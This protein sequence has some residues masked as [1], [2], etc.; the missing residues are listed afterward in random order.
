METH[1]V[2]NVEKVEK[3]RLHNYLFNQNTGGKADMYKLF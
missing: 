3:F 2:D 1:F